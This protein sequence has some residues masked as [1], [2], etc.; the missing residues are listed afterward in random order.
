MNAALAEIL[1][2]PELPDIHAA[3]SQRLA[4]ERARRKRFYEEITPEDKAEFINGEV[5]MHSPAQVRHLQVSRRLSNLL[6]NYVDRRGLGQVFV[7]KALIVTERNDFEPDL[8]FYGKEKSQILGLDQMKLPPPD[9]VVEILS[10]STE[11]RDRGIKLEAYAYSGIGEYWI[12]DPVNETV[13]IHLL[14]DRVYR[15][16]GI[17]G[18][19]TIRS[20][21]V[22]GFEVLGRALFDDDEC[23]AALDR[24]L[25]PPAL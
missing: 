24:I 23:R 14:A 6:S 13:E 20:E 10:Q 19:G 16:L 11:R 18:G 1:E 21:V 12:I 15:R 8:V 4:D 9:F 3:I 2:S 22:T 25:L 7:E 5:V 17:F